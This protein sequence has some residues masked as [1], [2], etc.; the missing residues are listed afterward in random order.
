M[1]NSAIMKNPQA[2]HS[3]NYFHQY[4]L[5]HSLKNLSD[6]KWV[7]IEGFDNY[8]VSNY[9][10][11][12]SLERWTQM[13]QGRE[14]REKEKIM[15]LFLSTKFNNYLGRDI[16]HT[17][18]RLC[19]NGQK[20]NL[21]VARLVFYHFVQNFNLDDQSIIVSYIDGNSLHLHYSNLELLTISDQ[22]FQMFR[23]D[24]A[25]SWRSDEK[26]PVAQY[27]TDGILLSRFESIYAA[28]KQTK[29]PSGSIFMV[30]Q[31]KSF[32]A[33]GYRW[34]P[35]NYE[36]SKKD[37]KVISNNK[38]QTINK[39]LNLSLWKK[40][41]KPSI[42]TL[43]PP[44]LLNLSLRNLPGEKWKPIPGF[45]EL[46]NI[47]NKGRVKKLTGW[48]GSSKKTLWGEQI[49]GLR[50]NKKEHS[51][52]TSFSVCL[53]R[54]KIKS[55][56]AINR[57]LYYCFVQEFDLLDRTQVVDDKNEDTINPSPSNLYLRSL[58]SILKEKRIKY[59]QSN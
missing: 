51:K 41:G 22:K 18:C 28:E 34:F 31:N 42:D 50:F 20:Y 37:F 46:Y 6:E 3:H 2:V 45:E 52:S 8:A 35:A 14:R 55:Q 33:G 32:T 30:L 44:A 43:R 58:S 10:R 26:Q 16:H 9:G 38:A 13:P 59:R 56:V 25:I 29:I 21:S 47:S 48:T 39:V 11:I 57:L 36:P 27:N 15:K 12:K 53:V 40:L 1:V 54:N 7:I 19:L 24:R 4:L 17:F 49:M 23:N 5:N